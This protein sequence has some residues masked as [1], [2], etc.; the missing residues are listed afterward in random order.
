MMSS[1]DESDTLQGTMEYL[2]CALRFP[3]LRVLDPSIDSPGCAGAPE[4]LEMIRIN[5]GRETDLVI[6]D[7][8]QKTG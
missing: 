7:V 6:C 5:L 4:T 2:Q 1:F 3:C 8:A